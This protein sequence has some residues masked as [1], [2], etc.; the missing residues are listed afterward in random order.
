MKKKLI[1][2]S[3]PLEICKKQIKNVKYQDGDALVREGAILDDFLDFNRIITY[4]SKFISPFDLDLIRKI[5]K[6]NYGEAFFFCGNING[7]GYE[8]VKAFLALCGIRDIK[9]ILADG[10]MLKVNRL[11]A[12]LSF[13][14]LITA[15]P[16]DM[17]FSSL[18]LLFLAVL[19]FVLNLASFIRV[20]ENGIVFLGAGDKY[21]ASFRKR[22]L[23]FSEYFSKKGYKT[24]V[25]NTH[26]IHRRLWEKTG[27]YDVLFPD[28]FRLLEI[29]KL[30]FMIILK[31]GD[32][33]IIYCQ[34]VSYHAIASYFA[35][36]F[37]SSRKLVVDYDDY[38]FSNFPELFANLK[39]L[40]F[41]SLERITFF[42]AK[43]S[44]L[45]V[46]ASR[47]L[48]NMFKRLNGKVFY[49]PTVPNLKKFRCPDEKI[50]EKKG[51]KISWIGTIYKRNA[52]W[53]YFMEDVFKKVEDEA[54]MYDLK[55]IFEIVGEGPFMDDVK[56]YAKKIGV[57]KLSFKGWIE[58]SA[59]PDYLS[60]VD[61][62][63]FPLTRN[64]EYEKSKSPTKLF[65]F[66]ACGIPCV[67]SKIG[68]AAAVIEDEI[69]GYLAIGK[70]DF[71]EKIVFLAKDY[72]RRK[73][74]GFMARKKIEERYNIEKA[75]PVLD[76]ALRKLW[77]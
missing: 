53:L 4:K 44:F 57:K 40:K 21:S 25:L 37:F 73:K 52:E 48:E 38:D 64:D 22:C 7:Q 65:E 66:M 17:V 29:I 23:E 12:L 69:D 61:I 30:Y 13:C 76:K 16:I 1:V 5:G 15:K 68:E 43:R 11:K 63:V 49:V 42:L 33:R 18:L 26:K 27:K 54:K 71:A 50:E 45:F 67:A 59:V 28:V 6:E 41:F 74:M 46:V 34:K 72:N 20:R 36:A 55:V 10:R 58:N 51:V 9:C 24:K 39:C 8:N 56:N 60:S 35:C 3:A 32:C 14:L 19:S 70:D 62:G 77:R 2:F 31:Y 47:H 75:L